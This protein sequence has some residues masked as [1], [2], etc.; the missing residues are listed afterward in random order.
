MNEVL[1]FRTKFYLCVGS[2][3]IARVPE[4]DLGKLPV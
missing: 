1:S 4:E 3:R 2:A